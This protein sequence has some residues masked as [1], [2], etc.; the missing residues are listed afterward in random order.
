MFIFPVVMYAVES[1]VARKRERKKI[2]GF[3]MKSWRTLLRITW[4]TCVGD[5]YICARANFILTHHHIIIDLFR[6]A[7]AVKGN[8]QV[9]GHVNRIDNGAAFN[10]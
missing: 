10:A 3:G 1:W 8:V 4:T 6:G 9:A 5:K 7:C 2:D